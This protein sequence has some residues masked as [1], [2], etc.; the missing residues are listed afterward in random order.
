VDAPFSVLGT[1]GFGRSDTRSK[2]RE[3][4]EIDRGSIVIA[5]LHSLQKQKVVKGD[6]VA[7][8]IE[9][10]AVDIDSP[11]PWLI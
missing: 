3:F 5:A 8:A 10:Y 11:S 7:K 4:F 2:L 6:L 1:D 9:T